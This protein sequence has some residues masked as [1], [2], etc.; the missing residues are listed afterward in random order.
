MSEELLIDLVDLAWERTLPIHYAE[1]IGEGEVEKVYWI[2]TDYTFYYWKDAYP[3]DWPYCV[4]NCTDKEMALEKSSVAAC[5]GA[6]IMGV[7]AGVI[8][9]MVLLLLTILA[10]GISRLAGEFW[11]SL[12]QE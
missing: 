3:V 9:L 4:A 5:G 7:A 12:T 6:L 2:P 11:K 1:R 10:R 8:A